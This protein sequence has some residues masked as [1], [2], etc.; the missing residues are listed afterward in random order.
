VL[1][2]REPAVVLQLLVQAH[3]VA[4]FPQ[5]AGQRRLAY[6]DGLPAEVRAVQLKQVEGVEE[7]SRL[8]PP[9]PEHLE[10]GRTLLVAAHNFAVE[11]AGPHFE[12]VHGLDHQRETGRPIV[13]PAGDQPDAAGVAPGHQPVAIVLDLMNPTL[14]SGH[15]A[16]AASCRATSARRWSGVIASVIFS[17][18]FADAQLVAAPR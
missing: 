5:D 8:V 6:L 3:A 2:H 13:A 4:A 18:A 15:T 1:K 12:V 14:A 17:P 7:R 9:V 11:Q 10:G 16:I